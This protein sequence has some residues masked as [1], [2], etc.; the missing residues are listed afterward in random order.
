LTALAKRAFEARTAGSQTETCRNGGGLA[1]RLRG[2]SEV[3][4]GLSV[5][6]L[7][8][9]AIDRVGDALRALEEAD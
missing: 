2:G 1:G 7:A 6:P 4:S 5:G 8:P 9:A 3:N